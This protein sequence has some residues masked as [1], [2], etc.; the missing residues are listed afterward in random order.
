MQWMK[1]FN[2]ASR[3]RNIRYGGATWLRPRPLAFR[4]ETRANKIESYYKQRTVKSKKLDYR[5]RTV[6]YVAV[7]RRSPGP[8]SVT[9]PDVDQ[10]G[11]FAASYSEGIDSQER[12]GD[13]RGPRRLV[14]CT[15]INEGS[16]F[17]SL[18][19]PFKSSKKG[20]SFKHLLTTQTHS[21]TRNMKTRGW[22]LNDAGFLKPGWLQ[23]ITTIKTIKT[24]SEEEEEARKTISRECIWLHTARS[25]RE[26]GRKGER[27]EQGHVHA[28]Y[29]PL[30]LVD[31]VQAGR[32]I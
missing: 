32:G 16:P 3:Q 9:L 26:R 2:F 1:Q 12:R 20:L 13:S 19:L 11:S 29:V 7:K 24:R 18:R 15:P 10:S 30:D 22:S 6:I 4:L 8:L 25:L 21:V 27:G 31:Y 23:G 17:I 28:R 5:I 14:E